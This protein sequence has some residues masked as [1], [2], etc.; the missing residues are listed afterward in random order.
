MAGAGMTGTKRIL[1]ALGAGILVGILLRAIGWTGAAAIAAPVG[2]LWLAGLQMTLVPLVVAMVATGIGSLRDTGTREHV[3]GYAIGVFASLLVIA[4]AIGAG[5]MSLMLRLWPTPPGALAGLLHTNAADH[6][7]AP[8]IIDQIV[9]LI[10]TNPIAAAVNGSFAPLVVFAVLL[11]VAMGQITPGRRQAL[12]EMLRALADAMMVIV[13]WLLWLAPLGIFALT[14]RA[15]LTTGLAIAGLLLQS[16]VLLSVA[17]LIG[18]AACYLIALI[19]GATGIKRFAGLAAGPQAV[20]AGTTSSMATLPSMIESAEARLDL[21]PALISAI[22]PLA[23]STFR[24]GNV[25]LITATIVFAAHANGLT[26]GFG[27]IAV[28]CGITILTNIG[29]IGLP[30]AAVLYAAEAP[31]F[32]AVGAPI[33]LL[34]L[35]IATSA[36]PD[37]LDTACNVT[38]DL[39]ALTIIGRLARRAEPVAA[40]G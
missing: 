10:P 31:G 38:A 2:Q 30:A 34:P 37:I 15:V 12:M 21:P 32:A 13:G 4:A 27:A 11:G 35:L 19:G 36:I 16:V 9:G 1:I 5:S 39:A 40:I 3:V 14:V 25:V 7:A 6:P 33:E 23:V 29:V 18:I 24:F 20:A 26:P 22:L 8:G 17:S 28:A